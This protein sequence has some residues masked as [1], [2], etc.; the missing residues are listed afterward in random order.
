M[1]R[2]KEMPLCLNSL[3]ERL[4]IPF[5]IDISSMNRNILL[6]FLTHLSNVIIDSPL[7]RF[8][9]AFDPIY[10]LLLSQNCLNYSHIF[11]QFDTSL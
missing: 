2:S 5:Q 8:F 9:Q 3:T 1:S 4:E 6:K 11:E 7:F 10:H